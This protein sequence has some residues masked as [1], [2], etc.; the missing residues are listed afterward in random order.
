MSYTIDDLKLALE[1]YE[2]EQDEE[3]EQK[4]GNLPEHKFSRRFERRMKRLFRNCSR[5]PQQVRTI[6]I[7][8]KVAAV[9]GI[10]ILAAGITIVSVEAFKKPF[11]RVEFRGGN[12]PISYDFRM[13]T[14]KYYDVDLTCT[15]YGYIPDGYEKTEE[16]YNSAKTVSRLR[17]EKDDGSGFMI[18]LKVISP[19]SVAYTW[20]DA[21]INGMTEMEINGEDALLTYNEG[22][23]T[24]IWWQCNVLC[25]L[26]GNLEKDEIIRIAEGIEL[27]EQKERR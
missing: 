24:L 20:T 16:T 27:T 13:G 10:A 1:Q 6:G 17:Y 22:E 4:Y 9:I 25:R 8:K 26:S 7:A 18:N 12:K 21:D 3:L 11:A 5:T 15:F 2:K 23:Y 19:G 14:A